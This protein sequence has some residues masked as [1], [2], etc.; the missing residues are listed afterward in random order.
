MLHIHNYTFIY[1]HIYQFI[2][3]ANVSINVKRGIDGILSLK[4]PEHITEVANRGIY[5]L[6]HLFFYF[7]LF[8][9]IFGTL[10]SINKCIPSF[11]FAGDYRVIIVRN[12]LE[13]NIF[14]F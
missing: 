2:L 8:C 5:L 7:V 6:I 10:F 3:N 9:F 12:I 11:I 14:K 13:R 4:L 1:S